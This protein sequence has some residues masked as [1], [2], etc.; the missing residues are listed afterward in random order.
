M[1]IARSVG[2]NTNIYLGEYNQ[3]NARY[4]TIFPFNSNYPFSQGGD[5][6]GHGEKGESAKSAKNRIG[7]NP[8][9]Q[10]SAPLTYQRISSIKGNRSASSNPTS[11][12]SKSYH[13]REVIEGSIAT[14][15]TK[16]GIDFDTIE[17]PSGFYTIIPGG[18]VESSPLPKGR[19]MRGGISVGIVPQENGIGKGTK[20]RRFS[21]TTNGNIPTNGNVPTN[22]FPTIQP[23]GGIESESQMPFS[24]LLN[25]PLVI[26]GGVLIGYF[27]LRR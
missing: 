7:E 10:N 4:G 26:I 14:M 5:P 23:S 9:I 27:L 6:Y 1:T 24:N 17:T 12:P 16:R 11:A 25:N 3:T 18:I 19:K 13:P 2:P 8:I 15:G 20:R 22:I 21:I